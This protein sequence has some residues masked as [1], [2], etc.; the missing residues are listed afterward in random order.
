MVFENAEKRTYKLCK[1]GTESW[2]L[3]STCYDCYVPVGSDA[4]MINHDWQLVFLSNY[5]FQHKHTQK[6][7]SE[8]EWRGQML[9]LLRHTCI[10]CAFEVQ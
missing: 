4:P 9:C 8:C 2:S 3:L 6:T 1:L 5:Q 10:R 7:L